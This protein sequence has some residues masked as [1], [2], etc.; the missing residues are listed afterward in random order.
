MP[1]S[2][3]NSAAS[4]QVTAENDGQSGLMKLRS[5]RLGNAEVELCRI[6]VFLGANGAGKSSLL[7]EIK[8]QVGQLY[9]G[10]KAIYVEGGRAITLKDS[11]ILTRQ[12]VQEYGD[13]T[14][15]KK[16]YES[17]RLQRPAIEST[18]RS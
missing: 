5:A 4:P 12:N 14:R 13:Y 3:G 1:E 6:N 10:K 11:L 7:N 16:T 15:A 9:P 2:A 8:A 17:K 18:M